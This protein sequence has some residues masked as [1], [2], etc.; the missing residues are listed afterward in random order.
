MTIESATHTSEM[1]TESQSLSGLLG[2]GWPDLA[3]TSPKQKTLIEFLPD[4]LDEHVFTVD[5]KH[6][7]T[8]TYNFG[9][10][11]HTLYK[12][13]EEIKYVD[14]D[15]SEGFWTVLHK[16]FNVAGENLK[17][18]FSSPKEVIVDTGTTIL[19]LPD[20]A[21]D[22]YFD[23]V[24]GANYSYTEY[25]YLVPCDKTPPDLTVELTDQAGHTVKSTV[26]G[27]YIVYAHV[28]DE[29]CYAGVQSLGSFSSLEGILGDV[30]LKSSFSVFDFSKKRYG[31]APKEIDTGLK[32]RWADLNVALSGE[33]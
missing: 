2:L 13:G 10:I 18:E 21:V 11:D 33:V 23:K 17:Y 16:G 15:T 5:M 30:F 3:Q 27:E 22:T 9:F 1:F 4:V 29:M 6:N 19:F 28:S 7:D 20:Q 24:P 14:V 26:P 8:G 12:K 32:R 31:V 25:G